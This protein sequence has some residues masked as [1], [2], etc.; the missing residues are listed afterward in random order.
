MLELEGT[1]HDGRLDISEAV[2]LP[3]GVRVRV[4]IEPLPPTVD[5]A[6]RRFSELFRECVDDPA[7]ADAVEEAVAQRQD[8]LP[9]DID[10]DAA[11]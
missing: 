7:F 9:R 2:D 1:I 5:E 3:D 10:L 6:R 8:N 11:P 4:T